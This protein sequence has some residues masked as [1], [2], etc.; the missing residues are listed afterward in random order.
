MPLVAF[1]VFMAGEA[2]LRHLKANPHL[3]ITLAGMRHVA[4]QF[5]DDTQAFLPSH[6]AVEHLQHAMSVYGLASG[7]KLSLPKCSLLPVGPPSQ[8]TP[9]HGTSIGGMPVKAAVATHGFVFRAGMDPPEPAQAWGD[10]QAAMDAKLVKLSRLPLSPFGR[11]IGANTYVLSLI[12]CYAELLDAP[13]AL[14][15]EVQRR[16]AHLVDRELGAGFTNMPSELL[17]GP[18]KMGG[19]GVLPILQHITA[20]HALW[21]VSLLT[22]ESSKP[23]V[24]LGRSLLGDQWG[25]ALPW[26]RILHMH[27]ASQTAMRAF[28]GG[29]MSVPPPPLKRI[30]GAL[31]QLPR[32][33]RIDGPHGH[34]PRLSAQLWAAMPLAGNPFVHVA[35]ANEVLGYLADMAAIGVHTLGRL[36]KLDG[37]VRSH[38]TSYAWIH[39][40][41]WRSLKLPGSMRWRD[42]GLA[43]TRVDEVLRTVPPLWQ[44]LARNGMHLDTWP[45][46]DQDTLHPPPAP[47][48]EHVAMLVSE[49]LGWTVPGAKAPVQFGALSVKHA[50]LLLPQ[51]WVLERRER[52]RQFIAEAGLMDGAA[53]QVTETQLLML[54]SLHAKLWKVKWHN[55]RKVCFGDCV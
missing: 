31:H 48:Y 15:G 30:L 41:A 50:T 39:G 34:L 14:L 45:E 17:L 29:G 43:R 46:V 40:T 26:H 25:P 9:A 42:V 13:A 2:M 32:A 54:Q 6:A 51:P 16:I 44:H 36:M 7:Q 53:A 52:W 20:R 28:R 47:D 19:M 22:G 21:A 4:K 11:A 10:L 23:W 33:T 27:P 37:L 24:L 3:D 8:D 49:C 55:E 18:V 12:M 5:A 35:P 38:P 1:A